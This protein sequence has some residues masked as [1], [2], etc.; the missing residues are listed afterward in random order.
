MSV[1]EIHALIQLLD[2]PDEGVYRHVREELLSKG[3]GILPT[4]LEHRADKS[5]CA[6]HESRLNELV[7]GLHGGYVKKG[8]RDWFDQGAQSVVEGAVWIHKAANPLIDIEVVKAQYEKLKRDIWLEL[9]EELTALEQV[10][11]LNHI[12]FSVEGGGCNGFRYNLEPISDE[13]KKIDEIIKLDDFKINVCGK[14]LLY[15]LGTTIDWKEDFMGS[16]FEFDNPN[17]A[18]KCGCGTTFSD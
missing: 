17:A 18:A 13:P 10:R 8:L 14:S 15:L 12:L 4:V 5:H 11:I 2:D 1:S 6:V 9:N 7:D 16:R 3:T